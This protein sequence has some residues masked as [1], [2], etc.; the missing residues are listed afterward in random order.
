MK[1]LAINMIHLS[2][3]IEGQDISIEYT[4]LRPGEK[5]YEE[6]LTDKENLKQSHNNLI[7]IADKEAT[8]ATLLEHILTLIDCAKRGQPTLELVALMKQIVPEFKSMNSIY[9]V[10]D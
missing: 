9:D 6:L 10:L 7:Y 8:T 2:G 3:L 5:L 4:G 1:D